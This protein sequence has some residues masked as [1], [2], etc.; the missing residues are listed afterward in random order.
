[1]NYDIV[2]AGGGPA[3]IGA[4]IAAARNGAKTLLVEGTN[5]LGGMLTNGLVGMIRTAGDNAGI[6][7]EFWDRLAEVDGAEVTDSHAVINPCVGRIVALDMAQ[8][9][10]VDVLL[11]TLA[12]EVAMDGDALT[13]VYLANKGGRQ[14]AECKVAVDATGDGDLAA[15]AGACY[16]KGREGDGYLQAVSLN[17]VLAG[18][19]MDKR[20]TWD[21][22]RAAC[23]E[24]LDRGE[25]ELPPPNR[26]LHF[27][28]AYPGAPPGVV[29]FQYDMA[30]HIDASDPRSLTEGEA[31]CHQRILKIWRFLKQNF[32]CYRNSVLLHIATYLG[33]RET[34][35][36]HGEKT[37]TEQDVLEA[38]KHPDG[39]ARCS[40]YMDL[41][42]GQD[43][44]PLQEYRARR[45]P[46]KGDFYEIP[47]GCLVPREVDNLLVS[48]RCISSTRPA[49]GSLRL[50]PTC[51]NTGQ[52]AGTAAALCVKHDVTPRQIEGEELRGILV[53]QGME[54]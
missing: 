1:M 30:I 18:V 11:H 33:V 3:G 38:R 5:C 12:E 34:R 45:A 25:I 40:W 54:L 22:F 39:I 23:E 21:E 42:D 51:M 24:A 29:E 8:G 52:A 31:I 49:N 53:R 50:Q 48:G 14:P 17:F 43:K 37:L 32:E 35:R 41:H 4:A 46:P 9:S 15:W 26:T 7:R 28:R 16:D 13:G 2:V 19:E 6:V 47:Y 36:I 20:P 27:G 10:G 44:H